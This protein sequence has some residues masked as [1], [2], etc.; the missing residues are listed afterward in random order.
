MNQ[1][2]I[3]TFQHA[4][5]KWFS[6][7]ARPL[8]WRTV[9]R[10]PYHVWISEIMLQQ[11]TVAAVIPYFHNF[12]QVFPTL[13]SLAKAS[14]QSVLY[15]WQGLGY[16]SRARNLHKCANIVIKN[17]AGT[18]P[19][20]TNELLNLP[21]IG[22]YTAAAIAVLAFN[23]PDTVVDGNVE[24]VISR[25]FAVKE[26]LPASK[27]AL[28][29]KAEKCTDLKNAATYAEAMMDLGATICTP[30]SPKCN[31]CPI[32]SFCKAVKTPNP[33]AF[34][35]RE[36]KKKI[37]TKNGIAWCIFDKN[38]QILL[39]QRP[40]RGLLAS[41]W[42]VPHSHWENNWNPPKGKIKKCGQIKHVF[43]HFTLK[44]DVK[45]IILKNTHKSSGFSLKNLP[46]MPTLMHKVLTQAIQNN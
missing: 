43:T 14:E 41:L 6:Q 42:E 25:L 3:P 16:Y 32:S 29:K 34:P 46:P 19:Q 45:M 37:P 9:K 27:P 5:L 12:L 15:N 30:T 22:P 2:E 39:R 7:H 18:F 20:T 21:G 35:Y 1:K 4:L 31:T 36:K 28:R 33:A 40:N 44:L 38:G 26:K 10:N 17:H 8:P 24:R 13:Q 11:T 23:Q